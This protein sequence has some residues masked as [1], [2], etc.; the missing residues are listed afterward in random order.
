MFLEDGVEHF[1]ALDNRLARRFACLRGK[2]K[3][4]SKHDALTILQ[5]PDLSALSNERVCRHKRHFHAPRATSH[6]A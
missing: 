5:R 2:R 4:R 6:T 3:A 1:H